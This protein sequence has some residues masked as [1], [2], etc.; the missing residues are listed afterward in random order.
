VHSQLMLLMA[1]SV[2]IRS[3]AEVAGEMLFLLAILVIGL[4]FA[5]N[6]RGATDR[7]AEGQRTP[8]ALKKLPP[9]KWSASN[10]RGIARAVGIFFVVCSS[11]PLVGGLIGLVLAA[12]RKV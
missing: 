2:S 5:T 6:F 10:P 7:W 12:V 4:V 9:W 1:V 11:V 3:V 8:D